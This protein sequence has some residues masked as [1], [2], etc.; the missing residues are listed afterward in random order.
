MA[1]SFK[2]P[3]I[4][5]NS[6]LSKSKAS[7][8]TK[9]N[10]RRKRYI[11]PRIRNANYGIYPGFH[12]YVTDDPRAQCPQCHSKITAKLNFVATDKG[13]LSSSSASGEDDDSKGKGYVKD[14]INYIVMDD[15]QVKP[16][17]L[18][19][20][21]LMLTTF[22]VKDTSTLEEKIVSIGIDEGLQLLKASME[23]EIVLTDVLLNKV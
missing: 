6:P 8:R 7:T 10:K 16:L 20:T 4:F 1:N 11:C 23:T 18:V 21:L 19:S 17:S 14:Q 9:S 5:P 13:G 15:L 3:L 22:N 12:N 2:P